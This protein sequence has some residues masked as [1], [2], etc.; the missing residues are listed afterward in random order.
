MVTLSQELL[1]KK[2]GRRNGTD[3][4]IGRVKIQYWCVGK[5]SGGGR[6]HETE[7]RSE[8]SYPGPNDPKKGRTSERD[9]FHA[10]R[11]KEEFSTNFPQIFSTSS[12]CRRRRVPSTA[13]CTT[14][15]GFGSWSGPTHGH[16]P[17]QQQN[18]K[19]RDGIVGEAD[20]P[21]QE[22]D[23]RATA[24]AASS[25]G[26]ETHEW[27]ERAGRAARL[28]YCTSTRW[29]LRQGGYGGWMNHDERLKKVS[30]KKCDG[31]QQNGG[32]IDELLFSVPPHASPVD[33]GPGIVGR[34]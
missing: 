13:I 23:R 12:A 15:Q 25:W 31:F 26:R 1:E 18:E 10:R 9:S 7:W 8:V 6:D 14:K 24:T 28:L 34:L 30:K 16:D 22:T 4:W 32:V 2:K 17:T 21:Y 27:T 19:A 11:K 29:L 5:E 33:A 20:R 3:R